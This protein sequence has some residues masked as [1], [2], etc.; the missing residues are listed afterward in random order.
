MF[1]GRNLQVSVFYFT[2]PIQLFKLSNVKMALESVL[3]FYDKL[4]KTLNSPKMLFLSAKKP[5]KL[6]CTLSS[7][8]HAPDK[9]T[10]PTHTQW[11]GGFTGTDALQTLRRCFSSMSVDTGALAVSFPVLGE[12]AATLS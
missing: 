9:H 12:G 8:T 1:Q 10:P 3:C 11:P 2:Y 7:C 4:I 6:S 5:C